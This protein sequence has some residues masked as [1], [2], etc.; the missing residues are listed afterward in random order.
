VISAKQ[1]CSL[2]RNEKT[3]T[4]LPE[5]GML[6]LKKKD[7]KKNQNAKVKKVP[8]PPGIFAVEKS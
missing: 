5:M 3:K 6:K 1:Y 8:G 4:R 2:D 7:P